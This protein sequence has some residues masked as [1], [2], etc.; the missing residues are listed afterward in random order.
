MFEDTSVSVVVR[1]LEACYVHLFNTTYI[2]SLFITFI[3][4]VGAKKSF[5]QLDVA[6]SNLI[7][8]RNPSK[9]K[10]D[11]M[12]ATETVYVSINKCT[13]WI[14]CDARLSLTQNPSYPTMWGKMV[15]CSVSRKIFSLAN[16]CI[17][18]AVPWIDKQMFK[19][20]Q[21]GVGR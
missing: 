18:T 6:N 13:A 12:R 5:V 10:Q 11:A 20:G 16:F 19:E 3:S 9:I 17:E 14:R 8:F 15:F 4:W 1:Q 7:N 21:I 2:Y